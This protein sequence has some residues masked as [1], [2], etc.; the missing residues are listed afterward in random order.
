MFYK[1]IVLTTFTMVMALPV[2]GQAQATD[3]VPSHIN[4]SVYEVIVPK[5]PEE[6]VTYEKPLPLH[7]IPFLIR[8]DKYYSIGTAFAISKTEFITAAHVLS[9]GARSQFKGVFLRDINGKVL[10]IDQILKFSTRR[11]FTVLTVKDRLSPEHLEINPHSQVNEKIYAVG[12]A[13]GV[14]PILS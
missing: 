9:L 5:P 8:N 6:S 2:M 14:N 10:A 7:F 12:N 1:I 13:L 11:D 4:N 3:V